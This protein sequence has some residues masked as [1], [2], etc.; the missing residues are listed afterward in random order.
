M[1]RRTTR[2]REIFGRHLG[3]WVE[4]NSYTIQEAAKILMVSTRT[5]YDY[6]AG[7]HVPPPGPRRRAIAEALQMAPGDLFI[8]FV[9]DD[10]YIR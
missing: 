2:E 5:L 6:M 3:N 7:R 4:R 1:P 10:E 8:E 9:E